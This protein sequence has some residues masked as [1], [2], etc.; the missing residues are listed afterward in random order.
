M[1]NILKNCIQSKIGKSV[2]RTVSVEGTP[3]QN[4]LNNTTGKHMLD[5]ISMLV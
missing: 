4:H 2:K 1:K 3:P 5:L